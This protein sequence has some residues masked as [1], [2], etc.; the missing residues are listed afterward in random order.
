[1]G[2]MTS[3]KGSLPTNNGS[4]IF[5]LKGPITPLFTT[6]STFVYFQ[7]AHIVSGAFEDPAERT[8]VFGLINLIVGLLTLIVQWFFT[9]RFMARVGV[10]A[11]L[12]FLPIVVGAGFFALALS[13]TVWVLI[14]FHSIRRASNFAISRPA[15]EVLFTVV[16]REDKYKSKNG[17]PDCLVGLSGGRDSSY[18]LHLIKK[19]N[20]CFLDL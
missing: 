2:G 10:G 15:R 5:M 7:Q 20:V 11:A 14:F 12:A 9:G 19:K 3:L 13:P 6:T 16:S 18:G 1:M 4:S 8:R 17:K